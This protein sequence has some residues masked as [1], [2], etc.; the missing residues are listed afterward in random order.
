MYRNRYASQI[1][2]DFLHRL[3]QDAQTSNY[4]KIRPFGAELFHADGRADRRTDMTKV[5]V[6]L[7]NSANATKNCNRQYQ[8]LLSVPNASTAHSAVYKPYDRWT[9]VM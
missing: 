4:T 5:M 1:N 7:H 8:P 3:S 6:A 9:Y 2:L